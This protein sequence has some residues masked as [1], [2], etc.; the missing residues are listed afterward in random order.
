M[1]NLKEELN[2]YLSR[3]EHKNGGSSS[4]SLKT[5]GKLFKKPETE[6]NEGLLDSR[7]PKYFQCD[8]FF[9]PSLVSIYIQI[10]RYKQL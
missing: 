3:N 10:L 9:C 5:L 4:I 6:Y 7:Q 8:F 2:E 1:T